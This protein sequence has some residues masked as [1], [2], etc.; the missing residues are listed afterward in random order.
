MPDTVLDILVISGLH[1]AQAWNHTCAA[2]ERGCFFGPLLL[3]KA[4]RRLRHEGISP[5]LLIILGDVVG[6]GAAGGAEEALLAVANEARESGL[7]VLTVP[8][9][10][11]R[12]PDR[13]AEIFDCKPGLH[14]IG[15]YGFL[16]FHDHVGEGDLTTRPPDGLRLP[17]DVA[18]QR[19]GLPLVALQHNPLHPPIESDYPYVWVNADAV[20]SGYEDAGVILSLS[21]HYHPGQIAHRVGNVVCCTVPAACE[22]PFRFVHV[23]LR[24]R[25]VLQVQE[26][27]L[28]L[29]TPGLV[30]VHCHTEYAYCGTTVVAER[31]VEISRA[32]GIH[33]LC[34]I[35][36]AF[37]LYFDRDDAWGYRWQTDLD[38]ARRAWATGRGR[39]PAYRK[40]AE[41]L[42]DGY[43][44]MGLEVDLRSDG[45]LLLA[46]EDREGWDLLVGAI[47]RI[48]G[49]ERGRTSPSEF[50]ILFL[51]EIE[52]LLRQ[53][54]QVLGHPFRFFSQSGLE[55]PV[56]LYGTVADM[57]SQSGVAAE[58]NFHGRTTN[59]R[60]VE[61]TDPHFIEECLSRGVKIA[62]GTDSHELAEVG[63]L[64]PHL[65]LLRQ[66]G[67]RDEELPG[68]LYRP[69]G[70][71]TYWGSGP[72]R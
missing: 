68:V 41:K 7:P 50:E 1:T 30:D 23:R 13:F 49:F 6:D 14:E 65:R 46:E 48:P 60:A 42:R 59:G 19:P 45:S 2:E 39:M 24:D 3:R 10:H 22:S 8:G 44:Q 38:L 29:D 64:A 63:E 40:F 32:M 20:L 9:N 55:S 36:H 35:E 43:V 21:G 26:H 54:I 61:T 57:L 27:A 15:G 4:I 31:N 12:D 5:D 67:V 51:R 70:D 33:G 71:T 17:A 52:G 34:L 66:I 47:H 69:C 28:R 18:S 58:M 56:H 37:Q 72:E 53:P 25:E 16:V 62:L 11:D